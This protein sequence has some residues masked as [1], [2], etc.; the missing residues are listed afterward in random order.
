MSA[1]KVISFD[2]YTK[3]MYQLI[4]YDSLTVKQINGMGEDQ[5]NSWEAKKNKAML[6]KRE[7]EKNKRK[8]LSQ[9]W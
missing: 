4:A 6:I 3:A 1:K 2:E 7:Y 8:N 9:L 5:L